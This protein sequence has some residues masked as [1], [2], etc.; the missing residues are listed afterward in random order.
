V[1]L[2]CAST[3]PQAVCKLLGLKVSDVE[4]VTP[5][6]LANPPF[7]AYTPILSELVVQQ[8]RPYFR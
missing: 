1:L 7:E 5:E 6:A 4:E 3:S 8:K 2:S